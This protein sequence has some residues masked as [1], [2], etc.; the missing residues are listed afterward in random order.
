MFN[1]YNFNIDLVARP[2]DNLK[3]RDRTVL[4]VFKDSVG[5]YL[6]GASE[7]YPD[8]IVRLMGGG[9]DNNE[10]LLPAV[11]REVKEETNLDITPDELVE[12]AQVKIVGNFQ[13][14]TYTHTVNI[15]YLNSKKDD[16]IAGDDVSNIVAYSEEE[17]NKLISS[18]KNLEP[19]YLSSEDGDGYSWGD[20]GKVYAFVHQ[21]A[22]DE[23]LQ[24]NL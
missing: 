23:M 12:L 1:T 24:R 2:F 10:E 19:S 15:Y 11:V 8:G 3:Y 4:V 22:L 18:F 9:V 20:Y 5:R 14:Q 13:N 6:L 16:L 7:Q 21:V 17:Y